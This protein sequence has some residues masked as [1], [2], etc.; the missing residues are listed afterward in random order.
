MTQVAC[1]LSV[2][3]SLLRFLELQM[4]WQPVATCGNIV[5]KALDF[6]IHRARE[7]VQRAPFD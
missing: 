5:L 4:L 2:V 6:A 7:L 1:L 3:Q